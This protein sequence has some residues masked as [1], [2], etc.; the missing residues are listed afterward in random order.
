MKP[1]ITAFVTS[2]GVWWWMCQS[3]LN[4]RRL[5]QMINHRSG[6][7]LEVRLVFA[8]WWYSTFLSH[9]T[10]KKGRGWPTSISPP[11]TQITTFR[12][13]TFHCHALCKVLTGCPACFLLFHTQNAC[14]FHVGAIS[15]II[16][17]EESCWK[18]RESVWNYYWFSQVGFQ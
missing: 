8:R 15:Y 16:H 7:D 6:S 17:C 11:S 4:Q 2:Q 14:M 3:L 13:G 12:R 18:P 1:V 9:E 5:W 10:V